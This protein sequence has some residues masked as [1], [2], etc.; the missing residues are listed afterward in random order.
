MPAYRVVV[1]GPV[2]VVGVLE[3]GMG[4]QQHQLIPLLHLQHHT[5]TE[6]QRKRQRGV[7]QT[8]HRPPQLLLPA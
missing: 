8:T 3:Q 5:H 6:R 2:Q 4:R 7:R 1:L